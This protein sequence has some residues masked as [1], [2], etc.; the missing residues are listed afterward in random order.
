MIN[1]KTYIVGAS[2][3]VHRLDDLT[4]AWIDVSLINSLAIS[5]KVVLYDVETDPDDG[6]KVIA[7]GEGDPT[8]GFFGIYVSLNGG[9]TWLVPG[10][11]YQTNIIIG[12]S[13]KWYEVYVLN[14]TTIFVSG[15]NGYI[16]ISTDGGLTFNLSTQLPVLPSCG[17]CPSIIP[18]VYSIHFISPLFGVVGTEAHV[19]MTVD[20]GVTWIVLNGGNIITGAPNG[21]MFICSGI[22]ISQ[23]GLTIVALNSKSIFQSLDG[24]ATW[25]NVYQWAS[26]N[27][28][29]LTWINDQELW[30]FG[31]KG[32]KI[33]STDGGTNWTLISPYG[34]TAPDHYA[35]HFYFNQNGFY[36]EDTD[37][38]STNNGA[39]SGTL[40]ESTSLTIAAVWTWYRDISCYTLTD[41]DNEIAPLLVAN[42]FSLNIGQTVR[43]C[44]A[45]YPLLSACKCFTISLAPACDGA[46]YLDGTGV[47]YNDCETCPKV[48]YYLVDCSNPNNFI[49]TSDDF[50]QQVGQVVKLSECPDI[51]WQVL[52]APDCDNSVC[53]SEITATF[54]DCA[55]C[56]P[57]PAEPEPVNLHPRRVKPGYYTP[58][59]SPAYTEKVNCNYADQV[60]QKMVAKRYGLKICCQEDFTK[61]EI[62][63]ELLDLKSIY[64]PGL[65]KCS[66]FICC[67]PSCV[68]AFITVFNPTR[69]P[70]PDDVSA[71]IDIVS[72]PCPAPE[73]LF[74]GVFLPPLG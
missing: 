44:P 72:P 56:L 73:I 41:C 25:T 38:L 11:N 71:T 39:T 49:V 28:A 55:S 18:N 21:D 43:L 74:S 40:S 54:A 47:I 37:I 61:W 63:K 58:G 27:G 6:N 9:S 15:D 67:P 53:V 64:D 35:G 60:Y 33:K 19:C 13:R 51:C 34:V 42:D 10:G 52:I 26:R 14:S 16:A 36:S 1:A 4:G 68:E 30:G 48:C 45:D 50:S 24:G 69:C 29:H 8:N 3:M 59:C 46:F 70:E 32:E 12:S 5:N 57:A 20:G 22:H 17:I 31:T 23:D 7:V 65:C 62:K 2:T 66:S